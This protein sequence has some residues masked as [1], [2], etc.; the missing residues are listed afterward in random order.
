MFNI[1]K[2]DFLLSEEQL[3]NFIEYYN[4]LLEWNNKFNIT[5]ITNEEDVE[6]KHF[7]DSLKGFT[8]FKENSTVV[9]IGSGGGFPSI[10]LMIL[11]RD[12]KFTLIESV[13]KKCLFLKEI[14]KKLNLNA[15]VLNIRAEDG[16]KN[17]NLRES[18]DHVTARAVARLNTLAEYCIPFIKIGGTF[19][20]YKGSDEIE[21]KEAQT[22]V[23][24]LGAE[25]KEKLSYPLFNNGKRN[26]YVYKKVE[27][28]D[29]KYPRGN[30]KERKNPL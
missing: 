20:A 8:L 13:G 1:I 21:E 9:E 16:A 15:T 30:G 22:A 7:Y 26:I 27:K 5:S 6:I 23:K 17:S 18:F 12:L 25:F 14:I 3:N 19:I 2:K 10:P 28:T 11:R 4:L 24:K 29:L